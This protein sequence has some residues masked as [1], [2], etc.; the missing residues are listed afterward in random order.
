MNDTIPVHEHLINDQFI[1][2]ADLY[3]IRDFS[4]RSGLSFIKIAL[5][6]GYIS[7]KNYERLYF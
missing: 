1:T 6:F 2:N 3:K 7:R 4:K 5:T